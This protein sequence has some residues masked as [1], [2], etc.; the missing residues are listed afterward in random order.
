MSREG[1]ETR[2]LCVKLPDGTLKAV[3]LPEFIRK[4]CT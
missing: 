1:R 2:E 3:P 4:L